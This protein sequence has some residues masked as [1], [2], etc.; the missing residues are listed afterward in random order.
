MK[1]KNVKKKILA[2]SVILT[3]MS[4]LCANV[5]L[6]ESADIAET[7][8]AAEASGQTVQGQSDA[9]IPGETPAAEAAPASDISQADPG[10]AP[11]DEEPAVL[12]GKDRDTT[13]TISLPSG[14]YQ[15]KVDIIFVMDNS[16]SIQ[17]AS[18]EFAEQAGSLLA[19]IIENNTG[20]ELK[21]GVVKFKG[22]ATDML[23]TKLTTYSEAAK[24]AIIAAISNNDVREADPTFIAV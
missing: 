15:N 5:A 23:G 22:Y 20:V 16:K 10:T 1:W 11:S 17:N 21:V 14:E 7:G 24:D 13:V 18:V 2:A 6:A 12:T 9:E 8:Q 4:G 3:L 19:S